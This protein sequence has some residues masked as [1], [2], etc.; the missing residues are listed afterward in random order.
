MRHLYF[1]VLVVSF[2]CSYRYRRKH[3]RDLTFIGSTSGYHLI[4]HLFYLTVRFVF[5]F[6]DECVLIPIYGVCIIISV[7]GGWGCECVFSSGR[8]SFLKYIKLNILK[9]FVRFGST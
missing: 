4:R 5:L 1:Y 9:V 8:V 3:Y 7:C 6:D 2:T